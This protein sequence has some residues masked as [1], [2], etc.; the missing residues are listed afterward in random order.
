[1]NGGQYDDALICGNGH[2]INNAARTRPVHNAP[3]CPRCGM[4]AIEKCLKCDAKIRGGYSHAGLAGYHAPAFC[5]ACG[6]AFPWTT[7]R[8]Q[9]ARDLVLEAA[10][11]TE[12]ERQELGRSLDDLVKDTPR[13]PVAVLRFRRLVLKA[14]GIIESGLR[15]ALGDIMSE[16]VREGIWPGP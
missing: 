5:H 8:L 12:E 13:T 15:E 11:L 3:F 4:Q 16:R 9:A 10:K 14:G 2:V 1:M 7:T 6:T